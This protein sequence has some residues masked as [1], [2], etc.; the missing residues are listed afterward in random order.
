[1]TNPFKQL[2]EKVASLDKNMNDGSFS[3]A[4]TNAAAGT[5][6]LKAFEA[7]KALST[8]AG[9]LRLMNKGGGDV[10]SNTYKENSK[11]ADN[12]KNAYDEAVEWAPDDFK[13]GGMAEVQRKTVVKDT[14]LDM[15][16]AHPGQWAGN[17][18]TYCSKSGEGT[19]PIM[20][21]DFGVDEGFTLTA[22]ACEENC[23]GA[24]RGQ[25][26]IRQ[27]LVFR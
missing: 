25:L 23:L 21:D 7:H 11:V 4:I 14:S 17:P 10:I 3:V 24:A 19:V 26:C 1:M 20:V 8:Y 12:L 5:A 13:V 2:V 6:Q 16:Q 15:P 18:D 9:E 27:R 22:N